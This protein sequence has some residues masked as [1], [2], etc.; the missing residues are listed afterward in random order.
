MTT[1]ALDPKTFDS[2]RLIE[3]KRLTIILRDVSDSQRAES[4][5]MD[6]IAA[7]AELARIDRWTGPTRQQAM[8]A[9]LDRQKEIWHSYMQ[10]K[11]PWVAVVDGTMQTI[12][13][14]TAEYYALEAAGMLNTHLR[15]TVKSK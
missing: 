12:D 14:M 3:W 7:V 11:L 8:D 15:D 2:R 5:H 13:E 4:E 1:G 10:Y 9:L 6:Y